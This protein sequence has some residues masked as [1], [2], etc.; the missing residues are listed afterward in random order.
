MASNQP[1][2]G[3]GRGGR[4]AALL[5]AMHAPVRKPG[6]S[7]PSEDESPKPRIMSLGRGMGIQLAPASTTPAVPGAAAAAPPAPAPALGLGRGVLGR[8]MSLGRGLG[9]QPRTE[10][11]K[12]TAAS[13][14]ASQPTS[15]KTA[16]PIVPLMLGRG[17]GLQLSQPASPAPSVSSVQSSI[18]ASTAPG[19]AG[20]ARPEGGRRSTWL[21]RMSE[22][23]ISDAVRKSGNKGNPVQLACNYIPIRC[24]T[25]GVFQYAVSYS[26]PLDSIGLR[27]S[28]VGEVLGRD[29]LEAFDGA[30]LFLPRELPQKE[31]VYETVRRSDGSP[32]KVIVKFVKVIPPGSC[33]QHYNI[34]LRTIMRKLKYC[35]VGRNYYNSHEPSQIPQHK[36]EV[37]SG[38]VST[39]EEFEGGL[40]L[41]VD[42]DHRILR[43]E[44]V[45]NLMADV[46]NRY[47]GSDLQSEMAKRVIGQSVLTRYN[48][49]TYRI[50]DIDWTQT[51]SSTFQK[52]DNTAVSYVEYYRE[53]YGKVIEDVKQ[54][55]LIHRPKEKDRR[56]KRGLPE[57]IAL[58][59]ELS[60]LTGLSDEMRSDFNV[61]KDV[62]SHT[63]LT[64]SQ[65]N[66]SLNKFINNILNSVEALKYLEKWGLEIDTNLLQLTGRLLQPETIYWGNGGKQSAGPK[67]NFSNHIDREKL[68]AACDLNEWILICTKRDEPIVSRFVQM[69]LQ[70]A[71]KVGMRVS[72]PKLGILQGDA[73][74]TYL[75]EIRRQFRAGVTQLVV[76]ICPTSRDDRY[77]AI[78]KLCYVESPVA[79]QVINTRTLR[80]DKK[81]RS[82]TQ[83][84]A[85]QINAKLGGELWALEIPASGLMVCGIDVCHGPAGGKR[86]SQLG[87][88]ASLN[89]TCTRWYSTTDRHFEGQEIADSLRI[90]LTRA[91]QKYHKENHTMP[92][93]IIIFRDGVGDGA[94]NTVAGYE[95]P[96]MQAVFPQIQEGYHPKFAMIVVQ[97][98]INQRIMAIVR[99]DL[100]NPSP[101]TIVDS[102]ITRK[103]WY[104]YF[105]VSQHV[106]Q[107]TVSPTHFVVVHDASGWDA[108]KLQQLSYKLTHLYYNWPGTIR[109]PAPCQYAHKLAYMVSQNL[110]G[111][112]PAPEICDRL[113]YL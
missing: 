45:Y 10:P 74:A 87:F 100:A 83:K 46:Q 71:G 19:P 65:R 41:M 93:R 38:Y 2:M 85:L 54:P 68:R 18:P 111:K 5:Q 79:S 3:Y 58:I 92:D 70:E 75:T 72:H 73:T 59:P 82:V 98:R 99:R 1:P 37:W 78:K 67:A 112:E 56:G 57:V 94:L 20:D 43:T 51:P 16:A 53:Q 28:L 108:N 84:I 52:D 32:V 109:V 69:L 95:V 106:G 42:V 25:G 107:G 90:C 30:L 104:D 86:S 40:M 55:L 97:K 89:K 17:R 61:M 34:I 47:Q 63:R 81:L 48:N 4:G 77:N 39:I 91:L 6:E 23:Q 103:Q 105:L 60:H 13:P 101:G 50:D 36:L 76:T 11:P 44:T 9:I 88:V 80:N 102:V 113:F 29:A 27:R 7:P 110:S 14:P 15:V 62:G 22:L 26:P 49:K 8:G 24:K 96:Q 33:V 64:P 21:Q 35:Q 66:V 31:S 12:A